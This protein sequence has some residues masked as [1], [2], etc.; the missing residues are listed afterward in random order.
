MKKII[1]LVLP[2]LLA[3]L[4]LSACGG[5]TASASAG[6]SGAAKE[7]LFENG[8]A[9]YDCGG[10]SFSDGVLTIAAAGEY[11]LSGSLDGRIVINTGEDKLK[12][13]VI[14]AGLTV[15]CP[16]GSAISV[17]RA[18]KVKIYSLEGTVN[19]IA[20][21]TEADLSAWTET[22]SGAAVSAKD[23]IEFKGDGTINIFG[24]INSGISG[25]ND[26]EITSGVINVTAANNG[27]KGDDSVI[28]SGGTVSVN[29]GND[30][31]KTATADREGK[32]CV[33]IS[34]GALSVTA[35]G[36]AISAE[37]SFALEGGSVT[38][39]SVGNPLLNSCKAVKAGTG[40]EI[41]G[42]VLNATSVDHAIHSAA[43]ISIKGG[44]ITAVSTGAK[45]ISVHGGASVSGGLLTLRA[46][47]E[48]FESKA[49]FSMTGG[50]LTVFSGGTALSIGDKDAG[51]G[52]GTI[53]GGTLLLNSA[54]KGMKAQQG[55][56]AGG[57]L[58]FI[59]DNGTADPVTADSPLKASSAAF[60]GSEGDTA[61]IEGLC[62][63]TPEK[64]FSRILLISDSG[65]V[66]VK[67]A[68]AT[69]QLG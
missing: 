51:T 5:K 66:T 11:K 20:S 44:E 26:V 25:K 22:A 63:L 35:V 50:E 62:S 13:S 19:N 2:L 38:A 30:G 18:D 17:E 6:E 7:I 43:G 68:G 4:L 37:T 23:D 33:V 69:R 64:S 36:D 15:N 8:T 1:S 14:L 40:I 9:V 41:S 16:D 58:I 67:C 48:G 61:E 42:G 12:V 39:V 10:V 54:R 55:I 65:T 60:R 49:D 46:Y 59:L 56:S 32:G 52:S 28:L 27:I 53:S 57:C 29:A 45:A 21:G 3:A 24:Y 34:G 47:D 31:I